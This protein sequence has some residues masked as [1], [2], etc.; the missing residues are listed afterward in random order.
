[1]HSYAAGRQTAVC[2]AG[3]GAEGFGF[4][5]GFGGALRPPISSARFSAIF[6]C[7]LSRASAERRSK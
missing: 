3:F 2:G 4:G 7:R 5:F 6:S 1:M